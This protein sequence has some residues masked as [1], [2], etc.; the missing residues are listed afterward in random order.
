MVLAYHGKSVPVDKIRETTGVDR[1]GTTAAS[2][3]D[4]ARWYGLRGRGV[5]SRSRS[6]YLD[7]AR[8]PPLGVQPLR[9]LRAA[10]QGR[11]RHR[12]PGA[13]GAATCRWTSSARSFTGVALMFETAD[14][15]E[16]SEKKSLVWRYVGQILG[17]SRLWRASWPPRSWCSS[18]PSACRCSP[19]R[20]S[21]AW[22]RAATSTCLTVLAGMLGIVALLFLASLIRAHLLLHLRTYLDARMTLGFLDHMTDLPYDFFQRRSAGDLMMRLNTNATIREI[23]T[24]G[25]L[26]GCST[27]RWPSSTSPSSSRASAKIGCSS[28]ALAVLQV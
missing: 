16:P 28:L 20:S 8:H 9:R 11:R 3:V 10:A 22:C 5:S 24:S 12:R 19:A 6:W 13:S 23:L 18:S 2:I 17:Q 7:P 14:D 4:A 15:F 26:S 1:N 25:A 21:T 27:A